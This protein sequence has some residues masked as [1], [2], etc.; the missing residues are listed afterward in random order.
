MG[1]AYAAWYMQ[2]GIC[3]LVYAAWYMQL[4]IIVASWSADML[5]I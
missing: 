2:L 3:S 1:N 4:D 5:L